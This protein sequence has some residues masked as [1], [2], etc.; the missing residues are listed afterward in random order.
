MEVVGI[1]PSTAAVYPAVE[2][3]YGTDPETEI[4]LDR[5]VITTNPPAGFR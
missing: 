4:L 2:I 5:V 3:Q 1:G